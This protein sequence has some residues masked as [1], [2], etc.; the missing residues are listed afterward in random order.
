[1][2]SMFVLKPYWKDDTWV[3]DDTEK[4][5]DAEPFVFGIPEIINEYVKKIPNA[6]EGFKLIFSPNCFPH[7]DDVLVWVREEDGGNWYSSEN[8][9]VEG[10]LCPALFKYFD[11]APK[12]IYFKCEPSIRR[13]SQ[14]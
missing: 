11:E 3:F 7:S 6:K 10:W 14:W 5:L 13:T 1:M 12:K 9:S 4:E 2:N 8:L